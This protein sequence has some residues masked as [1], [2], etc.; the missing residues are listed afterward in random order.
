VKLPFLCEGKVSNV[1]L[2]GFAIGAAM[3]LSVAMLLILLTERLRQESEDQDFVYVRLDRVLARRL[4]LSL[5]DDDRPIVAALV[6]RL[7]NALPVAGE[8]SGR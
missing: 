5:K 1:F 7:R 8:S 3:A 6:N 2:L 4:V